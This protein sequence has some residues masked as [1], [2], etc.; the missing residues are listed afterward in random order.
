VAL[1][2][3]RSPNGQD[4]FTF[5]DAAGEEHEGTRQ[6]IAIKYALADKTLTLSGYQRRTVSGGGEFPEFN[7]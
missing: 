1:Y 3:R 7:L 6:D 5:E 2:V 4:R